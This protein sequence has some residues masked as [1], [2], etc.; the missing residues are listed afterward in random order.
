M[1]NK[2]S[3]HIFNTTQNTPTLFLLPPFIQKRS[4]QKWLFNI[5]NF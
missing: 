1:T 2:L 4:I 3:S 5:S